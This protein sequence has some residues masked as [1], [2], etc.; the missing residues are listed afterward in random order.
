MV[1]SRRILLI[2]LIGAVFVF[3]DILEAQNRT[4][5]PHELTCDETEQAFWKIV[6]W[7]DDSHMLQLQRLK[8]ECFPDQ[9]RS[10]VEQFIQRYTTFETRLNVPKETQQNSPDY[11]WISDVYFQQQVKRE[12]SIVA[13]ISQLGIKRE[14]AAFVLLNPG[15]YEWEGM[16]ECPQREAIFAETYLHTFPDTRLKPY[17]LLFLMHRYRA[18]T[19]CR[20]VIDAPAVRKTAHDK[21]KHYLQ[22]ARAS[23]HPLIPYIAHAIHKAPFVY[24]EQFMK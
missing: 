19:E 15:C 22:E 9:L 7:G 13:L 21:Y 10:D 24:T 14:A 17:L 16:A 12:R 11:N 2:G 6:I 20:D 18:I 1:N 8:L 4:H 23:T 3:P 5:S